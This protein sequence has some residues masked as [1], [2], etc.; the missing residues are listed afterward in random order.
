MHMLTA[1]A[2]AVTAALGLQLCVW[3]ITAAD[4]SG[5]TRLLESQ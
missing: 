4:C 3:N 5:G 2:P 1:N